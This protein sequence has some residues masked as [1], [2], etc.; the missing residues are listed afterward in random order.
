MFLY[1]FVWNRNEF[2]VACATFWDY[3][4]LVDKCEAC[5][6]RIALLHMRT[7]SLYRV[8]NIQRDQIMGKQKNVNLIK[9]VNSMC[10]GSRK[11]ISSRRYIVHILRD[12][13][14]LVSSNKTQISNTMCFQVEQTF[15][16]CQCILSYD[17]IIGIIIF[18]P[19]IPWNILNACT[20]AFTP[21][22]MSLDPV[23]D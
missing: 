12:S 3:C 14:A 13:T 18:S 1:W 21:T 20:F 6:S 4:V 2:C 5:V 7:F 8:D 17:L 10:T 11:K 19:R 16:V 22:F 9:V 15:R 23:R